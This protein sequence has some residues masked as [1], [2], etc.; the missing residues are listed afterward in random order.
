VALPK[1]TGSTSGNGGQKTGRTGRGTLSVFIILILSL[2]GACGGAA[3]T[4]LEARPFE[5]VTAQG[6]ERWQLLRRGVPEAGLS[7]RSD[8]NVLD[9]CLAAITSVYG[10]MR[11]NEERLALADNC[12]RFAEGSAAIMPSNSYAWYLASLA[13]AQNAT[14]AKFEEYWLLSA[15]TGQNEQWIAGLRVALLEDHLALASPALFE[16]ERRDLAVLAMSRMGI[17]SIARRYVS[18]PD[19]RERVVSVVEQLPPADQARFLAAVT[20]EANSSGASR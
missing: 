8:R 18:Q 9:G 11:S 1:I 14:T 3:V 4:L 12:G 20:E 2:L 7:L 17:A 6:I 16:A 15:K 10:R 13:A 5:L 19:F